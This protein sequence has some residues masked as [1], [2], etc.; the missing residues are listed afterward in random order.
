MAEILLRPSGVD[1]RVL[2]VVHDS[3]KEQQRS[4]HLKR[5]LKQVEQ[6]EREPEPSVMPSIIS[7]PR[8]PAT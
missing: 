6:Y 5:F 1:Q 3:G 8:A 2:Q 4:D 7:Q